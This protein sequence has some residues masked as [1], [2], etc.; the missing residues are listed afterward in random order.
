[1]AIEKLRVK[2]NILP[3]FIH[4]SIKGAELEAAC[5]NPTHGKLTSRLRAESFQVNLSHKE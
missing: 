3:V 1:M 4:P 2:E 5:R